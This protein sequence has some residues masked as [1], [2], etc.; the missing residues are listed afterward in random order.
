MFYGPVADDYWESSPRIVAINMEAYGYEDCG[1]VEV[2]YETLLGWMYNAGHTGTK[3][4]R[5]TSLFCHLLSSRLL[6]GLSLTETAIKEAFQ[7]RSTLETTLRRI[8]YYNIRPTSNS[9]IQQDS[10]RIAE[11]GSQ[12]IAAFT[13]S[14]MLALEPEVVVIGGKASL[15]AFNS[16]WKLQ[17]RMSF[18]ETRRE[19]ATVFCS[20]DHPSRPNYGSWIT[21]IEAIAKKRAE[22]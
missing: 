17:T 18:R 22:T 8:S 3:T 12:P 19:G 14:E 16:L 15:Q 6:R 1:H 4:V 21:T 13:L 11:A 9:E 7:D 5:Y 20:I 10:A 2:D